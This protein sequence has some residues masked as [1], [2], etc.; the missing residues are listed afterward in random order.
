MK[1]SMLCGAHYEGAAAHLNAP[2]V[3]PGV[4]DPSV[5]KQSFDHFLE[6]AGMADELGFDWISVSE[7]HSSPLILSSSIMPLAGAL[8]QIVKR[9]RIALLGPLAPISNPVRIAEEIAVLDQL[10]N[11]RLVVLPL[12]GTPNEF[13][14]Y[15]P[16]E[17]ARTQSMTQEATRL[18][19]K[20]LS[21]PEPFAW[22]G[23]YYHFPRVAVWPRTLQRPYPPM[24]F[25]G[26]SLN[27]AV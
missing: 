24:Y 11:G 23:D 9:A 6:Y 12:R 13:N 10:S 7:H 4:C 2:P 17:A 19:R 25:S 26:N 20:A 16:V 3:A 1:V 5:A 14:V 18:I 21:E 22:D 27:S 8:T 15:V